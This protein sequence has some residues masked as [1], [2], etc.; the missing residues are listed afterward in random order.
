MI[1]NYNEFLN[2]NF[3]ISK[4]SV[5]GLNSKT[6]MWVVSEIAKTLLRVNK[7]TDCA[8][9]IGAMEPEIISKIEK[10]IILDSNEI[11]SDLP[12]KLYDIEKLGDID[13]DLLENLDRE[14]FYL[15]KYKGLEFIMSRVNDGIEDSEFESV[16]YF[17]YKDSSKWNVLINNIL[18]LN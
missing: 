7:R 1:K 9:I 3:N 12:T 16:F 15:Y 4:H 13:S 8:M 2:E 5:R 10:F 18:N 6:F 17:K 14:T 11:Y